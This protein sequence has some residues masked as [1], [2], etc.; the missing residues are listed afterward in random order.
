[1]FRISCGLFFPAFAYNIVVL[2]SVNIDFKITAALRL[3]SMMDTGELPSTLLGGSSDNGK[4]TEESI[5]LETAQTV[6]GRLKELTLL[7]W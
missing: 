2:I 7:R 4:A 3:N 6:F 1:M 5:T